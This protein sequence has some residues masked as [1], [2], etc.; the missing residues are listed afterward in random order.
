M[1]CSTSRYFYAGTYRQ[2]PFICPFLCLETIHLVSVH[3]TPGLPFPALDTAKGS[4]ELELEFPAASPQSILTTNHIQLTTSYPTS[5][6]H[7][8]HP[9]PIFS[10]AFPC[11]G[12]LAASQF[13]LMKPAM[14]LAARASLFVSSVPHKA[15]ERFPLFWRRLRLLRPK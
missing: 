10:N 6:L 1:N 14:S 11:H 13:S 8:F 12:T 4:L 7:T 5:Y 9:M 15:T 3:C 2:M